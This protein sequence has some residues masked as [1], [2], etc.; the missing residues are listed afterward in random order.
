MKAIF[1]LASPLVAV[2]IALSPASAVIDPNAPIVEVQTSCT[3]KDNCFTTMA[4]LTSWIAATRTPAAADPLL[5]NVGPGEFD[6]FLCGITSILPMSSK[7][8]DHTTIRGSGR[9]QTRLLPYP[10]PSFGPLYGAGAANCDHLTFE[11]LTITGG[12]YGAFWRGSGDSTWVNVHVESEGI[13]WY[14]FS[15]SAPFTASTQKHTWFASTILAKG[16][17]GYVA[18]CGTNFLYGSDIVVRG[19]AEPEIPPTWISGV[20]VSSWGVVRLFGSAIWVDTKQMS[21]TATLADGY[22]ARVAFS[23]NGPHSGGI[24]EMLG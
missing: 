15:C 4:A 7:E 2:L 20:T 22:G 10:D 21:P 5:V 17:V 24:F 3:G 18:E 1:H 6:A 16:N 11:A 19:Q 9:D 13:G 12:A 23:F 14:D 8:F